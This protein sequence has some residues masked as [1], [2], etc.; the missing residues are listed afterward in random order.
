MLNMKFV[1]SSLMC[2]LFYCRVMWM[3]KQSSP[4]NVV[5]IQAPGCLACYKM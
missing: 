5:L 1:H 4:K 2:Q 3:H